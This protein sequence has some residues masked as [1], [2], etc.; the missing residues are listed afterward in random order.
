LASAWEAQFLFTFAAFS[1]SLFER[2]AESMEVDGELGAAAE[3]AE[4]VG[5]GVTM[6]TLK[7]H[8]LFKSSTLK[9]TK[10]RMA[11]T[12]M[13]KNLKRGAPLDGIVY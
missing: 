11:S 7:H 13:T 6:M 10:I 12:L 9:K 3:A 4:G 5:E 2:M 8:T 1:F